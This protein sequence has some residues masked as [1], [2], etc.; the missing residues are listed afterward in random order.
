MTLQQNH[1]G[2]L[3]FNDITGFSEQALPIDRCS[4]VTNQSL[5][6][7]ALCCWGGM[8]I[9]SEDVY[10]YKVQGRS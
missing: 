3:V 8:E 5:K 6:N 7:T 9:K 4:S 1:P 10:K 2:M